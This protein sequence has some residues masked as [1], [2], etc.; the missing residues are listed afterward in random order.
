M[1]PLSLWTL[2]SYLILNLKKNPTNK[3]LYLKLNLYLWL[4]LWCYTLVFFSY[5]WNFGLKIHLSGK[6]P[7]EFCVFFFSVSLFLSKISVVSSTWLFVALR[8]EL[9][10]GILLCNDTGVFINL[11]TVHLHNGILHSREKEG[12]YTLSMAWMELESIMLSKI[13]QAVR[14]KYHV[15]SPLTG[16]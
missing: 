15:I 4:I 8:Q 16:I 5:I 6:L 12:A 3:T 1:F 11:F 13:S 10:F 2:K 14:D 7:F 9:G